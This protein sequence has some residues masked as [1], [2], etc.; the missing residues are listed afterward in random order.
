MGA[1]I[2]AMDDGLSATRLVARAHF[3][4]I[5]PDITARPCTLQK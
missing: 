4:T 5:V 3:T 2:G 1:E